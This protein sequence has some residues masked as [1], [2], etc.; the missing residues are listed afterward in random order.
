[1]FIRLRTSCVQQNNMLGVDS[2]RL[3]PQHTWKLSAKYRKRFF[4]DF[5][6]YSGCSDTCG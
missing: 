4:H 2:L 6:L 1:M 3:Y 5:R